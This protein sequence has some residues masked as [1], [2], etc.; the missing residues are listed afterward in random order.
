M[1]G[2]LLDLRYGARMLLRTPGFTAVALLVLVL[3]IG[4]NTAIFSVVHAVLLR[5]LPYKD[6]Q[7]LTMVWLDNRRLGLKEDLPSYPMFEDWKKQ[8]R[9]F[10][11]MAI[12]SRSMSSL[13]GADEPE[14][15]RE[16]R[17]A[18]NFFPLLGVRPML[19]RTFSP[20]ED[21]EG[22]DRV[23]VLSH[24]LWVRR[25]GADSNVLGK[26]LIRDSRNYTVVGVMPPEFRFPD[27]TTELWIPLVVPPQA[28]GARFGFW[29]WI[30][31]KLKPG[32][33]VE[34]AQT[35]MS[36][37]GSRLEQQ[38]P[39]G[40]GYGVYV[41][42]LHRQLVGNI[43]PALLILL[44]AVVFVLLMACANVASLL[45]ARASAR[46][47]EIAIRAAIGAG[48][49]RLIRQLLT[50]SVLL[51]A[52]AGAIGVLVAVW[53]VSVLVSLSP[54]DFPRLDE[55]RI[56]APVLAFTLGLSLLTGIV[57]GLAPALQFSR[58]A[59]SETLKETGRT[60]G[61]SLRA[62][63]LR[64][65]LVAG[66][67]ALALVLLAGAGL[68]IRSFLRLQAVDPGF[69][70]QRVLTMRLISP[71]SKYPQ[72][73]QVAALFQQLLQR[74][75]AMPGVQ[76]AAAVS[77]IFLSKTP[78]SG[79]FTI[80]GRPPKP[81]TE[82]IEATIDVISP[83]YFAAMGVPLRHGRWFT[84]QD[85]RDTPRVVIIN[86]TMARWFWPDEDPIGKRF[87]FGGP[88]SQRWMTIV[89][90]AGDMRRQGLDRPAR[91]ET[92]VPHAQNPRG[93]MTLVVRG[94]PSGPADA[95]ALAAGV[96]AEIRAVDKDLPIFDVSTL[97]R[98]IGESVAQRRVNTLLLGLFAGLALV[99]AAVG[100]YGV[101][102]YA[103]T[104]R[105]HE[106]GV[107]MA[108]GA[109]PDDV[110]RMVLRHG[111]LLAGTGV[112]AG[113]VAS[114]A[115]TRLMTG[116]LYGVSATDPGVFAAVALGLATVSLL[117][118]WIPA[119]RA[120]RV[121]PMVALRYE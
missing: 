23:A 49:G 120:T 41:V 115:L 72:G 22:R 58:W 43:R 56:D 24:G 21:Q 45:L 95:L 9:L 87:T 39:E 7:R 101:V 1:S 63:Y 97:D 62:R 14:Q 30:V 102:A 33:T 51:S 69:Q 114:L 111:A 5:Q 12:F 117:A 99:L 79:D 57:F 19:G 98:Q 2:F 83:N 3:G 105:T 118:A 109:A 116:L 11:D 10:E 104:Q 64:G 85:G 55:I 77:D 121:D 4:A 110:L 108:L 13:T 36:G 59:V 50:E 29:L 8:S 70:P 6:A 44:G 38:Y 16:A 94:A 15:V 107:R 53:G 25:F 89:G 75:G 74:I 17:V 106:I 91:A 46:E 71:R 27:K 65:A 18:A 52:V 81:L 78:N 35:E 34:Q 80:E 48:Q 60:L 32:V 84:D 112:T 47:R 54:Q 103:V 100:V 73:P 40:A 113:L 90:V 20:D 82:Q 76:S 42:P 31:G 119:R 67:I 96:R 61:S 66:E 28:R 37:I 88:Q 68:L 92:F 26:N 86:E 93:L